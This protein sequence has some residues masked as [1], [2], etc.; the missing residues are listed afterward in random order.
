MKTVYILVAGFACIEGDYERILMAFRGKEEA[1]RRLLELNS[2]ECLLKEGYIYP[3]N[4][5][6]QGLHL[7]VIPFL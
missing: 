7:E 2:E 5:Y 1:E 4:G 6:F 3:G